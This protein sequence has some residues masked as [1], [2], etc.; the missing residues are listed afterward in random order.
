[1]FKQLFDNELGSYPQVID[2]SY[3]LNLSDL[4]V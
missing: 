4:N 3:G 2:D 1:M